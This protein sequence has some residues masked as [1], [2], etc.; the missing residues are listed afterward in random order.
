MQ[1]TPLLSTFLASRAALAQPLEPR[2]T[3]ELT[4]FWVLRIVV[5]SGG[6]GQ[7]SLDSLI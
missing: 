6:P 7:V 5:G 4:G 2:S 3:C 1:L